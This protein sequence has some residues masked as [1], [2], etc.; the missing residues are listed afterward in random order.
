MTRIKIP[1]LFVIEAILLCAAALVPASA[2]AQTTEKKGTTPYV[3]HFIFR[4]IDEHRRSRP[5]HC[6]QSGSSRDHAKHEWR[7]DAR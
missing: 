3:T 4:P 5:W 1:P 6:H 7:K 2:G